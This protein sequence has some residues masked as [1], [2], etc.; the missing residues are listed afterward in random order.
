M[1]AVELRQVKRGDAFKRK[2]D[3]KTIFIREDYNRKSQWG[4]ESF[5]CM[6]WDDINRFIEL[7]PSTIVYVDF[8][9]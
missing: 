3:A 8:E 7:K 1:R 5:S 6:D 9:Y 4:P 2:P